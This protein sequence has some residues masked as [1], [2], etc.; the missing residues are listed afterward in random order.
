MK[1][2]L[3]WS[4]ILLFVSAMS[5]VAA[6]LD[7]K[8]ETW[9]LAIA[10]RDEDG[11]RK[12]LGDV[13]AYKPYPWEWGNKD[14]EHY[15]IVVVDGITETEAYRMTMPLYEFPDGLV[16]IDG[17]LDFGAITAKRRYNLDTVK[18]KNMIS[19]AKTDW[20]LCFDPTSTYQPFDN[21]EK[22]TDF[23]TDNAVY[24]KY[25]ETLIFY[26]TA[27]LIERVE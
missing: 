27:P 15:L 9:E 3:F 1:K 12:K 13:I 26:G 23:K 7:A 2:L 17:W 6:V 24:D 8:G 25:N 16:T 19:D 11:L 18:L 4:L 14:K 21:G 20:N 5:L 22:I 10:K